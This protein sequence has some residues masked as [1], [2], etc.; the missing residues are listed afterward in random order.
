MKRNAWMLLTMVV[1]VVGLCQGCL[2]QAGSGEKFWSW[3]PT[4]PMGWNSW[5]C[6]G[7]TV[8]EAEV[9]ANADYMAE[10]L[11]SHGWQYV[12]VDIRWFVSNDKAGGYNQ[13]DP[14]YTVDPYGRFLPATNRFPSAAGGKGFKPLADYVHSK[15]LKFGIHVMRGVPVVA[16]KKKTPILG[17]DANAADIYTTEGQCGWLRDMYTIVADRKGAAE[18]YHSIFK[19]YASWEIDY[20]KIDDLSKPYHKA[21]IEL[22]RKAIDGCGRPIVLSTSPGATPL[23][24]A[25]HVKT[26]ANLWRMAD[27][28]WDQ[29]RDIMATFTL[30]RNWALHRG[31]GHWP[32]ADMLPLGRISIRGER[33]RDRMTRLTHDEQTTLMTLWCIFRSPLMFGGDLPSNDEFTLSLLTNDEVVAVDQNGD[34]GRELFNKDGLIAWVADVPNSKDRY[35]ALFNTRTAPES[36]EKTVSV[37]VAFKELGV[38]GRCA[39]RDLWAKKDLGEFSDTFATPIAYH[40]AGLYRVSPK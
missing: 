14:N 40:G 9:K 10:K 17:S 27:D 3:A 15:G 13:K 11:K 6:Y 20:I 1:A 7:P 32:D 31:P 21:E 19:L 16:V 37:Q 18:Y 38:I 12:I 23:S 33:G 24:E 2:G 26:H 36:G 34:G 25:E 8:T 39:L 29:W 30:C 35:L 22:I 4:P 5:D 28:L